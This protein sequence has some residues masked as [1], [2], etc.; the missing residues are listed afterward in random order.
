M[1]DLPTTNPVK[2]LVKLKR[3]GEHTFR[4]VLKDESLGETVV[5]EMGADGRATRFTR[6]SNFQTRLK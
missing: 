1:L 2:D 6:H 4:R 5:F 3:A